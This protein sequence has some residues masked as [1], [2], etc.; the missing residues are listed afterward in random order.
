MWTA[1]QR[2]KGGG[3]SERNVAMRSDQA[4]P[5]KSNGTFFKF[6]AGGGSGEG[7]RHDQICIW[8]WLLGEESVGGEPGRPVWRLLEWSKHEVME[9][10]LGRWPWI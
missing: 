8:Q 10:R 7:S 6:Q 5:L 9:L 4:G 1:A 3:T 2:V